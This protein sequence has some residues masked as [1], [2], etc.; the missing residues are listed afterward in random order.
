MPTRLSLSYYPWI[1]QSI[2]GPELA[3]EIAV[4]VGLLQGALREAMGNALEVE[5]LKEMEIPD[6]L[7]ELKKP[8]GDLAGKIALLNP[9]GYALLHDKPNVQAVAV[10]RRKIGNAKAGPTYKAQLYTHRKTAIKN[11]RE[12]RGRSIAFGSPQST[13]NFLVPAAEMLWEQEKIHPLNGFARVEFAGG[14]DKA[15][16]AVYEGRAEVGAGHDGAILDLADR[17]GYRDADKVLENLAWSKD[18]PSDPVAIHTSDPDLRNQVR[19]ALIRIANPVQP[20][21][22]GNKAVFK[23][24]GKTK[25]GFDPISPDAEI[26]PDAYAR[27]LRMMEPLGLRAEDMLRKI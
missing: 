16:I 14:H 2:S 1:T 27:L 12:A 13:S 23:F 17:P 10:V 18:I 24:W 6:Q 21:S 3:R 22:D 19:E 15:A 4:F 9:I 20:D 11:V 26:R 7:E 8:P 5:L 25:E